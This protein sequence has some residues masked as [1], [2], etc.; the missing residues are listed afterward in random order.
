MSTEFPFTKDNARTERST[1][2]PP[3]TL[4]LLAAVRVC[5]LPL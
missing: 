4:A 2:A 3:P 1:A 5:P